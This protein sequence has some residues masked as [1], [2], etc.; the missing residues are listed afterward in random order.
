MNTFLIQTINGEIVHDFSFELLRSIE[1]NN[2][3]M[4]ETIY[5]Y[6]TTE[7]IGRR[8]VE[9][10]LVPVGTVEFVHEYI[11]R[12][13]S[14]TEPE[15]LNIPV[16]LRTKEFLKRNVVYINC[17]GLITENDMFIKSTTKVKGYTN[18]QKDF[19][20][21]PSDLYMVSDLINID[22]E[23][24]CFVYNNELV[25]LQNYSGDFTIF[26]DVGQIKKMILAFKNSPPAYT[27]DVGV[28]KVDGTF[29]IELHNFYS[30]GLYGFSDHDVLPKMFIKTYEYMIKGI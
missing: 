18:I 7:E 3:F 14:T 10:N 26:P 21:I 17:K 28:N 20:D 12:K 1:W 13:Y 5:D 6:L 25:G 11:D 19:K 8:N 16:E 2:W 22:S 27:L 23:Y 24:R 4:N 30:C 15:P 9:E 29:I